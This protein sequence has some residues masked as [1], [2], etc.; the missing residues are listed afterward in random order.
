MIPAQ[1][2]YVRPNSVNS[3]KKY[4][5]TKNSVILAGGHSLITELKWR[6][7]KPS[8]VVD[9]NELPLD[10]VLIKRRELVVG[11]TVRQERFYSGATSPVE[12]ML[13]KVCHT[14]G[15]PLI[16]ARGTVVGALCAAEKAGDWGA[17][18]LALDA[19]L[20]ISQKRGEKEIPYSDWLSQE[21]YREQNR[22]VLAAV[23][24][25]L[26]K[27]CEV[28]YFKAK[29]AAVGWAIASMAIVK[30]PNFVR[31]AVSGVS[32]K[33]SRLKKTEQAISSGGDLNVAWEQDIA[34]MSLWGDSYASASYRLRMLRTALD[35]SL[36]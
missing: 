17:A 18:A 3:A 10:E 20:R 4:L 11:A 31:I 36:A 25:E 23:F 27:G 22:L 21:N 15:D 30:A 24:P 2:D 33:P 19:R 9:I 6:R 26:P 14:A 7:T 5:E 32:E 8:L 13:Q 16:R 34:Q 1:F 28:S 35:R 12:E 29:H